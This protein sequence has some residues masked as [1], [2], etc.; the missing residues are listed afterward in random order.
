MFLFEQTCE[1]VIRGRY[2]LPE[3]TLCKLAALRLQYLEGDVIPGNWIDNEIRQVFPVIKLRKKAQSERKQQQPA[4]K[5]YGT[6]KGTIKKA[7]SP[8]KAE[9]D[10]TEQPKYN[11]EEELSAIKSNV[12]TKWREIEGTLPDDA[13]ME[14]MSI[15]KNWH[16]FGSTMFNVTVGFLED[17]CCQ[18]VW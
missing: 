16:G 4:K 12:M 14:Y 5:D 10:M 2:L 1:N 3:L 6:I 18:F 15:V 7:I 9:E 8:Y 11:I 17:F 13:Q